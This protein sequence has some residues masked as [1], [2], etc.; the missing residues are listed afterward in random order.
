MSA[1]GSCGQ[2]LILRV[3]VAGGDPDYLELELPAASLTLESLLMVACQELGLE[4]ASVDRV[5]KMP[6]TRLRRDCEVAR[7][8][9][10]QA[11]ELVLKQQI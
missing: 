5:R 1:N 9:D 11:I 10:Y 2:E 8:Q 6:D 3:R 7:L 4:A